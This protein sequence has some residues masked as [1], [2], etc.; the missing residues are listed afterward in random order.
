ML[1]K[2]YNENDFSYAEKF[3][4]REI[5][6]APKGFVVMDDREATKFLGT[7]A[8]IK[9][10][11]GGNHKREGYKRLAII[12]MPD[13][14]QSL[15]LNKM[16]ELVIEN[17]AVDRYVRCLLCGFSPETEALLGDHMKQFHPAPLMATE[18]DDGP[19]P[20]GVSDE[21]PLTEVEEKAEEK[22]AGNRRVYPR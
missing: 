11:G 18:A 10:D 6:I 2:V 4:G 19:T 20:A 5:K 1:V 15:W 14:E 21:G 17:K 22:K 3:D 13:E 9:V 16:P 8:P 12:K 7:Y